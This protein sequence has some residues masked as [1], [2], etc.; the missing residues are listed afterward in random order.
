[1]TEE[2]KDNVLQDVVTQPEEVQEPVV[3]TRQASSPLSEGRKW[4]I[5]Q[6]FTGHEF[7]VKERLETIIEQKGL[8]DKV[9][10]ILVPEEETVEIKNN[11]RQEK[12]VKIYPGYAFVEMIYEEAT[13]FLI[14]NI[15]GVA[16]FVG[17]KTGPTPV[18]EDEI[19]RVLRKIGDKTR[20]IDV[21]FE[22][23]EA[24]KVI[25]GPFRGYMGPISEINAD[26][27]TLKALLSVFGRETPVK[28]DFDQVESAVE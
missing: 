22:I 15:A 25:A 2:L 21:D 23:G 4:Y 19:L 6:C 24:I 3:I 5:L 11:K 17:T 1:M 26:K 20:K 28:L 7:K 13:Y 8:Q 16:Q 18:T 12:S 9:F 10:R 27:G 14:R